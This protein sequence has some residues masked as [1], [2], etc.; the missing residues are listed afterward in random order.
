M[1]CQ[2]KLG[3]LVQELPK[4]SLPRQVF[5]LLGPHEALVGNI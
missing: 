5:Y 4:H 1:V 2:V 3:Y